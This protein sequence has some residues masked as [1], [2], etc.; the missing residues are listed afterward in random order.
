MR[1]L[2]V[3]VICTM[4]AACE[5]PPRKAPPVRPQEAPL[6]QPQETHVMSVSPAVGM[7]LRDAEAVMRAGD[8]PDGIAKARIA[9]SM[10]ALTPYDTH[11]INEVLGYGF[12]KNGQLPEAADYLERG[13]ADGYLNTHDRPERIRILAGIHYQLKNF[14]KA[15]NFGTLAVKEGTA[16]EMTYLLVGQ[17]YYLQGD[18]GSAARFL[19]DHVAELVAR[20]EVPSENSLQ[21]ILSSCVKTSDRKCQK[22]ALEYLVEFHPAPWSQDA[23]K[24]MQLGK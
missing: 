2:M 22:H 12:V 23:L 6:A 10:S 16:D 14:P 11:L 24:K 7:E 13:L 9:E 5:S 8:Y 3:V 15:V 4:F 20:H 21:L 17:S 1:G 19:G 18:Y